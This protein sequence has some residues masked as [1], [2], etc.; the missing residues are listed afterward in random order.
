MENRECL[1]CGKSFQP[2]PQ[3]PEQTY[4]NNPDCQRVRRR[5]WQKSKRQNDPDYHENQNR[6]Q[7]TWM[8]RHPD[9]W[10]DYRARH[11]QYTELNR[12]KQQI[13]NG[14]NRKGVIAKMDASNSN[15][16]P[17]SGIYRLIAM[18]PFKIAKM[19]AWTVVLTVVSRR[20]KPKSVIAKRG[21]VADS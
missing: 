20:R 16:P 4:C 13:R 18:S 14:E 12:A 5:R 15:F 19:D 2:R 3:N 1:S 6:A 7:Q 17:P 10:R 9:Y 11:P 8:E 21:L